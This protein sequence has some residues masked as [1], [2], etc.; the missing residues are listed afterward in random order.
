M[1]IFLLAYIILW[2]FVTALAAYFFVNM[3]GCAVNP[4][5]AVEPAV[6]HPVPV[7]LKATATNLDWMIAVGVLALV[8]G[9]VAYFTMPAA[10]QLSLTVGMAGAVLFGVS[11]LLRESLWL[12]PYIGIGLL[13]VACLLAGY[14]LYAKNKAAVVAVITAVEKKL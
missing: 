3:A 8:A 9:L 10:H 1:R 11:V 5:A 2:C 7:A 6:V 14:E 4:H 12:F 13:S